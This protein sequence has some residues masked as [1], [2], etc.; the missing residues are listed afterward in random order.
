LYNISFSRNRSPSAT[1]TDSLRTTRSRSRPGL[2][3]WRVW[4]WRRRPLPRR[5]R[6]LVR[7]RRPRPRNRRC[8][9][10]YP[11]SRRQPVARLRVSAPYSSSSPLGSRPGAPRGGATCC[12][13]DRRPA[14]GR[15]RRGRRPGPAASSPRGSSRPWSVTTASAA[16]PCR[17]R[18]PRMTTPNGSGIIPE[19]LRY[20][21]HSARRGS[22]PADTAVWTRGSGPPSR[23]GIGGACQAVGSVYWL[24]WVGMTSVPSS[25][26]TSWRASTT[27]GGP[28]TTQPS[29]LIDV[30]T[31][32]VSPASTPS[33]R[34]SLTS[35][36]TVTGSSTRSIAFASAHV[37]RE[38]QDELQCSPGVGYGSVRLGAVIPDVRTPA[39]ARR[40]LHGGHRVSGVRTR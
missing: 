38:K 10:R 3:G 17:E 29:A 15:H 31:S 9:S 19:T 26:S 14:G 6:P 34:K 22:L 16:P 36:E 5:V 35:E 18:I 12:C 33:S 11:L 27:A 25:V 24:V 8:S 40:P 32:S 37:A 23:L 2:A 20:R 7:T 28:P 4:P 1:Q 39:G 30:W 13:R 21:T